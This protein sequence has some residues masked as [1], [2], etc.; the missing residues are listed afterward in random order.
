M[1]PSGLSATGGKGLL[2][3]R[4]NP[5]VRT[6]VLWWLAALGACLYVVAWNGG[7]LYYFDTAGYLLRGQDFLGRIFGIPGLDG[8][9][10]D[11]NSVAP[12]AQGAGKGAVSGSR[13]AIYS[14]LIGL[15]ASVKLLELMP[16]FNTVLV[17]GA[18]WLPVSVAARQI[19]GTLAIAPTIAIPVIIAC[20]GS[21]PFYIAYLM[22]D[23]FAPILILTIGTL[24][25]FARQMTWWEILIAIGF[26]VLAVTTHVS[27][28]A[29]VAVL[30]PVV[31]VGSLVLGRTKWWLAPL[32][33]LGILALGIGERQAFRSVVKSTTNREVVYLPILTA[34][35]I[36]DG[37]GLDYLGI[38]CP[39]QNI[40][41]CALYE[42][43]SKSDDPMRL[44][45]SHIVF[46]KTPEL[47]SFQLMAAA[48]KNAVA[49]EQFSFFFD[50]LLEFPVRTP[51]AFLRNTL[52]QTRVNS[53]DMTLQTDE[54]VTKLE[55]A[56]G[57]AWQPFGHGRLTKSPTW[58]GAVEI[59]HNVLYAISL[60][61]AF[62]L[63]VWPRALPWQ[64]R[65]LVIMIG[66]GIL[67][68]AFVLGGVS[69]PASRYG[70]R[71]IWLL[72][73]AATL[74]VL[75]SPIFRARGRV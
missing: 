34:R 17:L 41:T 28:L 42:A 2:D 22:P 20:L 68:N 33:V 13:S 14:L 73:F 63:V 18:V 3:S 54:I 64:I 16:V 15:F 25:V 53:I 30:L 48:D 9:F 36:Q 43:L 40:A 35:L 65:A 56:R 37:M 46:A 47:G 21:L 8:A 7:L 31:A 70:G 49:T 52:I 75:Y 39:D 26:G 5:R 27:H 66:F 29:I 61:V 11:A 67:A 51:L 12:D 32:L 23:I 38:K 45:A 55:G 62:V 10:G 71:V 44:T 60:L 19:E 58:L 72:P 69:Q 59:G 57:L 1:R 6:S 50:V 74:C 24:T 4:P